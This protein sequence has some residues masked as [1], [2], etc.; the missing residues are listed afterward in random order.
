MNNLSHSFGAANKE[1]DLLFHAAYVLG[2]EE[3]ALGFLRQINKELSSHSMHEDLV[4]AADSVL[5]LSAEDKQHV[6]SVIDG[7]YEDQAQVFLHG[8][9]DEPTLFSKAAVAI[10]EG[11]ADGLSCQQQVY[12]ALHVAESLL[13]TMD[14][15]YKPQVVHDVEDYLD[16]L[17]E[18]TN[19]DLAMIRCENS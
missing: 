6:H 4:R 19:L 5:G 13:K 7:L 17:A 3:N 16:G 8:L 12:G 1:H 9:R 2:I 14:V 18:P 15:G 10:F 11:F